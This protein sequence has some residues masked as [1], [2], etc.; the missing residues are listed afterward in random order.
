MPGG[1]RITGASSGI[2]ARPH[3]RASQSAKKKV[4]DAT[5]FDFDRLL[6]L[7]DGADIDLPKSRSQLENVVEILKAYPTVKLKIGGYTDS[8]PGGAQQEDVDRSGPRR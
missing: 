4:A 3:R 7:G 5:W 1:Y 8:R 6:F 2:E